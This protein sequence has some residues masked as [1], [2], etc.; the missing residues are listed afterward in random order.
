VY[1]DLRE[2]LLTLLVMSSTKDKG[3]L[4]GNQIDGSCESI[5]FNLTNSRGSV[6]AWSGNA[7]HINHG[8]S[9]IGILNV[10]ALICVV[11]R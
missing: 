4:S 7:S 3:S 5:D 10:M 6:M 1:R 2:R 11:G 8:Q 9:M